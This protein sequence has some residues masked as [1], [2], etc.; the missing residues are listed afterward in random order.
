MNA[1]FG[2]IFIIGFV[3]TIVIMVRREIEDFFMKRALY[4]M[5][6]ALMITIG[7]CFTIVSYEAKEYCLE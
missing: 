1:I 4:Y 2:G 3:A 7:V 5:L 6:L